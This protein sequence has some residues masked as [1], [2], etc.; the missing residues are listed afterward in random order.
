AGE[1]AEQ[2][3]SDV[4]AERDDAEQPCGA[5][6]PIREPAHRHLLQPG[7]DERQPLSDEE[8]PEVAVLEGA[9][10]ARQRDRGHSPPMVSGVRFRVAESFGN[11][12]AATQSPYA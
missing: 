10:R 12:P 8:Q 2:Q 11:A 7:A 6:Q 3:D 4:A 1:I 5:R 9:E